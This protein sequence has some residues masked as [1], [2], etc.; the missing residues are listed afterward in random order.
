ME[1]FATVNALLKS[2]LTSWKNSN[3]HPFPFTKGLILADGQLS[4]TETA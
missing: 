1:I 2:E 3:P 4:S